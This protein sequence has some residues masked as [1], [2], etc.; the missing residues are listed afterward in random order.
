MLRYPKHKKLK[1][2]GTGN[3]TRTSQDE[4]GQFG[5]GLLVIGAILIIFFAVNSRPTRRSDPYF[6]GA[7][8]QRQ[9]SEYWREAY[10]Q[11]D[12]PYD[13]KTQYFDPNVEHEK[14]VQKYWSDR[15]QELDGRR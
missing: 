12:A 3:Q 5:R 14:K 4:Q 13:P 10:R 2:K 9:E 6:E 1:K 8:R 11:V 7:E 15:F